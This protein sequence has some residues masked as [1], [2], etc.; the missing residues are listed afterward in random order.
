MLQKGGGR[1]RAVCAV[2]RWALTARMRRFFSSSRSG[3]S[4][5]T[6]TYGD[7]QDNA[8]GI[9][10]TPPPRVA[11]YGCDADCLV[12]R[13]CESG[14]QNDSHAPHLQQLVLQALRRCGEVEK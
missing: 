3:L 7:W 9:S 5:A 14:A 6:S 11:Q 1:M 10:M 2:A 8:R 4:A 12:P 13:T